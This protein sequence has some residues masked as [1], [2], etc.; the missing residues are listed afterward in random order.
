[1]KILKSKDRVLKK[2]ARFFLSDG[3]L[4]IFMCSY[5]R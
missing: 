4:D 1:M 3:I 2:S 5:I